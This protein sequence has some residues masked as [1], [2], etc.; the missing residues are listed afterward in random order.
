MWWRFA[1]GAL[2]GLPAAALWV[3]VLAYLWPGPWQ[4]V[5]IPAMVLLFPFWM[6]ALALVFSAASARRAWV[7]MLLANGSG[8]GLLWLLRDVVG[9]V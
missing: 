7:W 8:F 5:L 2:L 4:A 6:S 9:L 3:G 1:A